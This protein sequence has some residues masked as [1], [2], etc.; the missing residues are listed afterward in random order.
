MPKTLDT[1]LKELKR[2]PEETQE[3]I[4]NELLEIV[5]SERQWDKLFASPSSES[6]LRRLARKARKDIASGDVVESDPA[7][8]DGP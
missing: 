3:A 2:L 5:R 6:A 7:D 4:A 8:S 1:A